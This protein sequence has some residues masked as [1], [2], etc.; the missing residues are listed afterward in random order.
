M[1]PGMYGFIKGLG[2]RRRC[3]GSSVSR[4]E[5]DMQECFGFVASF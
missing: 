4:F 2:A 3:R 5:G 1:Q